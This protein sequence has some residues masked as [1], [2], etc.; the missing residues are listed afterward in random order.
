MATTAVTNLA[1]LPQAAFDLKEV[2]SELD[3]FIN[4]T[5]YQVDGEH[6]I[7]D[8]TMAKVLYGKGGKEEVKK[9]GLMLCKFRKTWCESIGIDKGNDIR[10]GS[11][12]NGVKMPRLIS[13]DSAINVLNYSNKHK[14]LKMTEDNKEELNPDELIVKREVATFIKHVEDSLAILPPH[15]YEVNCHGYCGVKIT[16]FS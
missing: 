13:I 14:V 4:P 6:Y 15:F 10:K 5:I 1:K 11:V 3:S 16:F 8:T 2:I 7:D 9:F 12:M